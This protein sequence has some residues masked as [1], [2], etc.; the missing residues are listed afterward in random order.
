MVSGMN[1][2]QSWAVLEIG[3]IHN[4]IETTPIHPWVRNALEI[5]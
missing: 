3:P 5:L 1:R 4:P 2:F